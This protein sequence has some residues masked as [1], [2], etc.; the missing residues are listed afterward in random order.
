MRGR[1]THS[2]LKV[3]PSDQRFAVDGFF[4]TDSR[5]DVRPPLG[6]ACHGFPPSGSVLVPLSLVQGSGFLRA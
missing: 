2:R 6:S 5:L 1:L 3:S 4:K